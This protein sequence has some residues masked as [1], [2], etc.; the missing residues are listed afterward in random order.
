MT[1][2]SVNLNKVALLRNQRDL[3]YPSLTQMARSAIAAGAAGITVHPRP[4]ERHIR[5]SDVHELSAMLKSEYSAGSINPIEFNVEGYPSDDFMDIIDAVRPDQVTLVPD[6]PDQN[7]SDHGWDIPANMALLTSITERLHDMGCR[8]SLFV[9]DDPAMAEPAKATGTDRVELYTGPYH[10]AFMAG[11]SAS[12][13]SKFAA[14]A[15]AMADVGLALNAGHDLNLDNLPDFIAAIPCIAEV[16][17]GH[18]LW[19]DALHMGIDKTVRAY[20]ASISTVE[21]RASA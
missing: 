1:V 16:S 13:L 7:T 14:T 9:D 2:L 12:S 5:R 18:A 8:V 15:Q 17:I 19:A 10:A 21:T 20:V 4:D 11:N 3:R 6:D